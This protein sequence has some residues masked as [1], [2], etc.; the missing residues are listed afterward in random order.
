[1]VT[2]RPRS[3]ASLVCTGSADFNIKDYRAKLLEQI[4]ISPLRSFLD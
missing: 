4:L 1:M 2:D 3:V